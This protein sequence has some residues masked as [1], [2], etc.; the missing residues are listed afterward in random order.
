M[1]W[2]A[3]QIVVRHGA[4]PR[5]KAVYE[6]R[7]LLYSAR[8]PSHAAAR[9]KKDTESYLSANPEFSLAGQP[10]IFVL[11]AKESGLDGAEAWSCLYKG[12]EDAKKFWAERYKNYVL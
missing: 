4:L 11:N 8:S 10:S 9:A 12:P 2:F 3:V 5:G 1:K 6:E 7:I